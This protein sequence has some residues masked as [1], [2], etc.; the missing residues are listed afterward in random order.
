MLST[1]YQ[2]KGM[3]KLAIDQLVKALEDPRCDSQC[4]QWLRYE[5]GLLYEK[6]EKPDR[7]Y[8]QFLEVYR[9]DRSFRDV[10]SRLEALRERRSSP[11]PASYINDK[12]L[13]EAVA[14]SAT[15]KA[16]RADD[17]TRADPKKKGRVSYL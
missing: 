7:A 6:D 16:S 8:D 5:L 11:S 15:T 17:I 1:C 4:A 2:I 9:A 3:N 14:E 12:P 13:S 10:K